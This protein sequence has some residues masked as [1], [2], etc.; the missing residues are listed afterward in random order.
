MSENFAF[1]VIR[2]WKRN[3]PSRL[4]ELKHTNMEV[5]SFITIVLV[6]VKRKMFFCWNLKILNCSCK[7]LKSDALQLLPRL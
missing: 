5:K 4:S 6:Q 3:P 1:S 2:N 7:T